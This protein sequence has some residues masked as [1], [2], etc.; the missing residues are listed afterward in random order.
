MDLRDA[1]APAAI[2]AQLAIIVFGRTVL[3]TPSRVVYPFLPPIARGL[4]V[5]LP[6][7]TQVVSLR[8][9]AGLTA[10]LMGPLSDRLGRRR[11]MEL[12]LVLFALAGVALVGRSSVLAATVAFALYG[13]AKAIYDPAVLA[14]LG[15]SVPYAQRGR[16]MGLSEMSWSAAWLLGVPA[17]GFLMERF[18]WRT[19]WLALVFLGALGAVLTRL[20]LPSARRPPE[21]PQ[22]GRL[23]SALLNTWVSLLRRRQVVIALTITVLMMAAIE[24]PFVVYGAWLESAFGLSL[25]ALG[26]ASTVVGLAEAAAELGTTVFTDRLGK[27]RSVLAG[28]IGLTLSLVLLPWTARLGLAPALAGVVLMMLTFEFALVSFLPMVSEVA[29]DARAALLSFNVTA[30]SVGR[31]GA[32]LVSSWLWQWQSIA[33]QAWVGGALALIAAVSLALGMHE[34]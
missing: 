24:V 12:G 20:G 15:D 2:R 9:V 32:A 25:S 27:R 33:L 26:L 30:A 34:C 31:L 21:A 1:S 10:P 22:D 28:L 13:L 8:V 3:N 17:T 7:A 6:L 29:P 23:L 14:Y 5:S 19:P 11:I 4:G 16:A 18:G